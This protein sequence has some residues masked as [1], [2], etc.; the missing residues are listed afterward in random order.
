MSQFLIINLFICL[1]TEGDINLL[2][3][4]NIIN[5]SHDVYIFYVSIPLLPFLW[6]TLTVQIPKMVLEE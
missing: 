5:L 2:V 4:I 6:R 3:H 1:S